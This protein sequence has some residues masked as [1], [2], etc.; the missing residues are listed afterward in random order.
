MKNKVYKI[1][2]YKALTIRYNEAV[3]QIESLKAESNGYRIHAKTG[4]EEAD[5]W[6]AAAKALATLISNK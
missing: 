5:R 4:W 2:P 6:E 3:R 1:S